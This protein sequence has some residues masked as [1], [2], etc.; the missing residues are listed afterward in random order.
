MEKQRSDPMQIK[1][2]HIKNF[3]SIREL[4][5]RDIENSLILVGK[6]NTGKTVVLNAIR[7][8][9]GNYIAR[10]TDFNKKRT[11]L[12]CFMLTLFVEITQGF[13]P[14]RFCEIDDIWLNT[15]GGTI[16][17]YSHYIYLRL[18]STYTLPIQ[19]SS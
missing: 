13:I 11:I 18:R 3:K 1:S 15:L 4:E 6:N 5:I 12:A 2:L 14:Y 19:K 16:G 17:A 10:E 9:T 8:V 7:A